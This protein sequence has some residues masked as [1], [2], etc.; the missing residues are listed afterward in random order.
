MAHQI[1][2]RPHEAVEE[3]MLDAC[4]ASRVTGLEKFV[5]LKVLSLNGCG[6]TS[7]DGFPTLSKLKSLELSDN[8]LC[9]GV[10][11]ALQDAGLLHLTKLSLAGNRFSS[12]ESLEPLVR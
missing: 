3:L 5:N 2:L 6:L 7:L 12:L 10:L 11:E 4:K 1:G 9:D 8:Q